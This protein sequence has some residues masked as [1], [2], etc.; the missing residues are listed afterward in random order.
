MDFINYLYRGDSMGG[1][2]RQYT[3]I[4]ISSSFIAPKEKSS[5]N[6]R[7][8]LMRPPLPPHETTVA[9]SWNH[10]CPL[11]RP[12][13]PPHETT[14]APSW[15]HHCPLMRPPLPLLL[16]SSFQISY[17]CYWILMVNCINYWDL[18]WKFFSVRA[19]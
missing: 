14:V 1:G 11:M 18:H 16:S 9:P 13:L 10:R 17:N 5:W 7:C 4:A 12:P 19:H 3:V 2:G 8:P 15:D 6:H